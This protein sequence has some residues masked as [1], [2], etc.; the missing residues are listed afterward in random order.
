M[1]APTS[2]A[3]GIFVTLG[4]IAQTAQA[5]THQHQPLLTPLSQPSFHAQVLMN[6]PSG[7][8]NSNP[9]QN[10]ASGLNAQPIDRPG[11]TPTG[12]QA[13]PFF[14]SPIPNNSSYYNDPYRQPF[15][16]S[17][18]EPVKLK[19]NTN[20]KPAKTTYTPIDRVGS[21]SCGNNYRLR[22]GKCEFIR[23]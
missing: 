8:G 3:L 19:K 18:S 13:L 10:P 11:S 16:P 5:L 17:S 23:K 7:V 2:I 15:T 22:N 4:S 1:R 9:S 12:G 6:N 14:S 21:K 20:L